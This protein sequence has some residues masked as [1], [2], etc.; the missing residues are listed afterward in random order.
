MLSFI[1]PRADDDNEGNAVVVAAVEPSQG[2]V[3]AGIGRNEPGLES[4]PFGIS[5]NPY[6]NFTYS[7][8]LMDNDS[9]T[10]MIVKHYVIAL[11]VSPLM[12]VETLSQIQLQPT[13]RFINPTNLSYSKEALE[14]HYKSIIQPISNDSNNI[15]QHISSR[16][17]TPTPSNTPNA[18]H[19]RISPMNSRDKTP[20]PNTNLYQTSSINTKSNAIIHSSSFNM[21][22]TELEKDL[23]EKFHNESQYLPQLDNGFFENTR[24][25]VQSPFGGLLILIR[26]HIMT[27]IH[28][29]LFTISTPILS[30]FLADL[31][32]VYDSDNVFILSSSKALVGCI[33][34]P[35][36]FIRTRLICQSNLPEKNTY[37]SSLSV[38]YY[39]LFESST[40]RFRIPFYK[41]Q[42]LIPT[43]IVYGIRPFVRVFINDLLSTYLGIDSIW[44]PSLYKLTNIFI[45]G[46]EALAITPWEMI[47]KRLFVQPTNQ[48][49]IGKKRSKSSKGLINNNAILSKE[50]NKSQRTIDLNNIPS[51]HAMDS[52]GSIILEDEESNANN[53]YMQ[54][55]IPPSYI[56]GLSTPNVWASSEGLN[57][58]ANLEEE[59]NNEFLITRENN[60]SLLSKGSNSS[61]SSSTSMILNNIRENG[62]DNDN[63]DIFDRKWVSDP[64]KGFTPFDTCIRTYNEK[65][66]NIFEIIFNVF[67]TEGSK[68]RKKNRYSKKYGNNNKFNNLSNQ[69]R[70]NSIQQTQYSS[71]LASS[72]TSTILNNNTV[73]LSTPKYN[74]KTIDNN[75]S[76]NGS[77][78]SNDS[79][80]QFHGGYTVYRGRIVHKIKK[81]DLSILDVI[82]GSVYMNYLKSIIRGIKSINRGFYIIWCRE[83][84]IWIFDECLNNIDDF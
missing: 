65:Y 7:S 63:D 33:L 73:N 9:L 45:L 38:F 29:T 51:M 32:D 59:D 80:Y 47:R 4:L 22:N 71:S 76:P 67:L 41:L 48:K 81:E 42:F 58:K 82:N 55:N 5:L 34:L 74:K 19:N 43:A 15:S 78:H 64:L 37:S 11:L 10:S 12:V 23:L 46:L 49:R 50:N 72:S 31:F 8:V 60:N 53:D 70:S 35:F 36:E 62:N 18:N 66:S 16:S 30:D 1:V 20:S 69:G 25:I 40:G 26:G 75:D 44:T 6:H 54:T 13:F 52:S 61:L 21:E 3:D 28:S 83:L 84:L 17:V 56:S 39:S 77:I 79:E 2:E 57:K 14:V 27:F 68:S 24:I